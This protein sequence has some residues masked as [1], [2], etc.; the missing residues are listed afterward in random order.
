[1]PAQ[2]F[3]KTRYDEA[4]KSGERKKKKPPLPNV[5]KP[6][7]QLPFLKKVKYTKRGK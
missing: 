5:G 3:P 4:L 6:P 1:M 7:K 2:R